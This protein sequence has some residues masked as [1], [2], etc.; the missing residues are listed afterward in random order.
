[1]VRREAQ[2]DGGLFRGIAA[3][4]PGQRGVGE[5]GH[6]VA[7]CIKKRRTRRPGEAGAGD[8]A[9]VLGP[10]PPLAE[11]CMHMRVQGIC[12]PGGDFTSRL[13]CKPRGRL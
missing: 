7:P 6:D 11:V 4:D 9:I 13:A 2:V 8:D 12:Q 5:I 3:V 10:Q 1:M